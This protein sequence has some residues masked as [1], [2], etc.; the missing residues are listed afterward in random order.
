LENYY[1]NVGLGVCAECGKLFVRERR[2]KTFCSKTCQ[3]RVAYKRKKLL[4]SKA[5][6]QV[7]IP[8]DSAYEVSTKLWAHHPRYGIGRVESVTCDG[9]EVTSLLQQAPSKPDDAL[10]Y[11]SMISRKIRVQIRF[12]H[13]MKTFRYADLFEGQK[14]EDQLP[15]F[16]ELK[17]EKLLAELL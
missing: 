16:Y 15:T 10:R 3:N 9:A 12:M 13:G 11:R 14:K 4:D 8:P 7:F 5:L 6:T 17:S 1:S 2:D